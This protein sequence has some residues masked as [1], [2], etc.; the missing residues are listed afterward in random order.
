MTNVE[1]GCPEDGAVVRKWT[2]DVGMAFVGKVPAHT[3][4]HKE[5]KVRAF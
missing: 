5:G 1:E 4:L 3:G 2:T